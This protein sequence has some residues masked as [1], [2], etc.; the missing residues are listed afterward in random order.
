MDIAKT[1]P[2]APSNLRS[3]VSFAKACAQPAR[4]AKVLNAPSRPP[5]VSPDLPSVRL[6][7]LPR[8]AGRLITGVQN[9][10]IISTGH[11]GS[12]YR[13]ANGAL[14]GLPPGT[15]RRYHFCEPQ[16]R[17]TGAHRIVIAFEHRVPGA[18]Y[19][20]RDHYATFERVVLP[21][22]ATAPASQ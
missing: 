16:H 21:P 15:Y 1:N 8:K 5:L 11:N 7:S 10:S 4:P 3:G 14:P 19:Y 9:A 17:K 13:N 22:P 6:A 20:S 12:T 18:I 2:A